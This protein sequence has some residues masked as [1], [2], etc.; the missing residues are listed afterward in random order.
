MKRVILLL[1]LV[2]VGV[3]AF[4]AVKRFVPYLNSH[5]DKKV[6]KQVDDRVSSIVDSIPGQ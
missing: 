3:L 6:E 5:F 2:C 4:V 1:L